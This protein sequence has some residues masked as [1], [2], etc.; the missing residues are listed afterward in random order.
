MAMDMMIQ[1]GYDMIYM[2]AKVKVFSHASSMTTTLV[3][4]KMSPTTIGWITMNICP[5]RM[6]LNDSH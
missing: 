1:S 4:A 2:T 6:N 3:Q 5:L